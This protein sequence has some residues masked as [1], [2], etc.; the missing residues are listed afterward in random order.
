VRIDLIAAGVKP[1]AWVR[2]AFAEY[3]K[4]IGGGFHLELV[5]VAPAKRTKSGNVAACQAEEWERIQ[6]HIAVDAE[7]VALEVGGHSWSTAI[8]SRKLQD[9]RDR[10]GRVQM[11]IGGPD[12]L[13][14]ACLAA[15]RVRWSLSALTFPHMLVRVMVA[16]QLYRAISMLHKHP[17][18]R[19]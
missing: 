11:I 15:A 19:G 6:R 3:Q 12:G 14:P 4:R 18:H 2:E 8:L 17:Y 16:E 1:P 9:W 13:D 7:V 10:V 5:E